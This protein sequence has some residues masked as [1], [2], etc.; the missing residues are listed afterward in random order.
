MKNVSDQ[1]TEGNQH[2]RILGQRLQWQAR[3]A[4]MGLAVGDALGAT[5]EFLTPREIRHQYGV[6]RHIIG[7]GWL[8]LPKGQVTDDTSMTFALA[9]SILRAGGIDANEIAHGFSEWM[10]Q[11][12]VDIGNTVRRGIIHYRTS[13]NACM[14]ESEHDAGNG[15]CMR[16]LP[17]ALATLWG[18]E[19]DVVK[20]SRI[21][22]HITHNNPESDAGTECLMFM[23]RSIFLGADKRT[24][25]DEIVHDFVGKYPQFD[26]Q[27][28]KMVNPSGYIVDTLLV[29]FQAFFEQDSFEDILLDVVNRGGDADTTGAIA[30]M[31]A[32]AYYGLDS[33][34]QRW[35]KAI[36]FNV[37]HKCHDQADKLMLLSKQSHSTVGYIAKPGV[38]DDEN[39]IA[40]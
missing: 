37:T 8:K 31:L 29:V 38:Q 33:I 34:P 14:P 15:A 16:S 32:G 2:T 26:Y 17:I 11:K 23:L 22:A 3:G 6:H 39:R 9:E 1:K 28:R 4:Y 12:P 25:R 7:G 13:G 10:K 27:K 40:T 21:Q 20:A 24:L 30:G 5:V 19:S 18:N 35:I 36:D